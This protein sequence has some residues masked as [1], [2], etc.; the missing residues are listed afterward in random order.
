MLKNIQFFIV[1]KKNIQGHFWCA[2]HRKKRNH[3]GLEQPVWINY[4]RISIFGWTL[5]NLKANRQVIHIT[6]KSI[7]KQ[8]KWNVRESNWAFIF[9]MFTC[10]IYNQMAQFGWN[11][12]NVCFSTTIKLKKRRWCRWTEKPTEKEIPQSIWIKVR[13][14]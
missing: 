7:Y 13:L 4:N 6:N 10:T 9:A 2:L 5:S 1:W 8:Q 3:T 12:Q 14:N 11:A